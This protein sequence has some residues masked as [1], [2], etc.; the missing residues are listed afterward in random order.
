MG[1]VDPTRTSRHGDKEGKS[2]GQLQSSGAFT[3]EP[4][5]KFRDIGAVVDEVTHTQWSGM[6]SAARQIGDSW[7]LLILWAGLQGM[8]RFDEFQNDLG[9]A[10]NILAN[11]LA[12]LVNEGIMVRHPTHPGA[13]RQEYRLT[14]RGEALRPALEL[15]ERWGDHVNQWR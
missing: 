4:K 2:A 6:H 14:D 8:T 13:R 9:V 3:S 11:R 5:T 15:L 12:S 7:S 10:R 1:I